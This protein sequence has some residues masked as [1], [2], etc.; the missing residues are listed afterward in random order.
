MAIVY[1][2][3]DKKTHSYP[4]ALAQD[5]VDD[6]LQQ[7]I[8]D[9]EC[10]ESGYYEFFPNLDRGGYWPSWLLRQIADLVDAENAEWDA[11]VAKD[12]GVF[13]G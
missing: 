11:Q 10:T 2:R 13:D 6:P 8:G 7:R 3:R 9:L 5:S 4:I 12:V 1:I